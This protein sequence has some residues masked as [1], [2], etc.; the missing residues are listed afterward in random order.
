MNT[1][2]MPLCLYSIYYYAALWMLAVSLLLSETCL[3][4]TFRSEALVLNS[5]LL[6]DGLFIRELRVEKSKPD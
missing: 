5:H 3:L 4:R 6:D 2:F 1:I